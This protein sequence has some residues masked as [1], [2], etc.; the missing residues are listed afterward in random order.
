MSTIIFGGT[1]A[2]E[3]LRERKKREKLR[4]IREAAFSLF[5]EKGFEGTT[6]RAIAERAGIGTGTLFLYV[7]SKEELL[8]LLFK[9]EILGI[10]DERFASL[11]E[12][13]PFLAQV[14]HLFG[15]F[16]SFY[17]RDLRLARVLVK[18][19]TLPQDSQREAMDTLN[20]DFLA[21]LSVVVERAQ[22]RGEVR[23]DVPSLLVAASLFSTY[24]SALLAW[25]SGGVDEA[26][27]DALFMGALQLHLEGLAE[28]PSSPG[29]QT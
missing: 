24:V 7:K 9:D 15:G 26:A 28:K 2:N 22:Q 29:R 13:A 11:D 23:D 25:L 4:R 5:A 27:R 3:S 6:T 10:A 21:R 20:A 16:F 1:V 8:A 12:R 19:V 14:R 18:Q 17:A